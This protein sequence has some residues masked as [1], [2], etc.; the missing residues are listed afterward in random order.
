MVM[1]ITPGPN[2]I[3]ILSSGLN[4]GIRRSIPHLFGIAVGFPVM[5]VAVGLGLDVNWIISRVIKNGRG[6]IILF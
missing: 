3:M 2:N 1:T 4:L 5:L 6:P